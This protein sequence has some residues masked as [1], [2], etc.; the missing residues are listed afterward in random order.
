MCAL[1]NSSQYGRS[2]EGESGFT[3][4]PSTAAT[5]S[6]MERITGSLRFRPQKIRHQVAAAI[7]DER[8]RGCRRLVVVTNF[9]RLDPGATQG[10][11][12]VA[13]AVGFRPQKRGMIGRD[14]H[15][16]ISLTEQ[17]CM[18]RPDDIVIDPLQSFHLRPRIPLV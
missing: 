10:E 6:N 3:C 12:D 9:V 1:A 17:M 11:G 15:P 14:E 7:E 18:Q 5:T 13:V 8:R 2:L 4:P 16:V